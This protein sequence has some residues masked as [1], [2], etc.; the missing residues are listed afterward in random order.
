MNVHQRDDGWIRPNDP[1]AVVQAAIPD[2]RLLPFIHVWDWS[3]GPTPLPTLNGE[4]WDEDVILKR[5]AKRRFLKIADVR[6][7]GPQ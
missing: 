2:A 4:I 3:R 7:P 5:L 6:T 1:L